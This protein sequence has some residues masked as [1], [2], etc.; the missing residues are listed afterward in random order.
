MQNARKA[1]RRAW[2]ASSRRVPGRRR[3]EAGLV[4]MALSWPC[5]AVAHHPVSSNSGVGLTG[6]QVSLGAPFTSHVATRWEMER[7]SAD[8]VL[9]ASTSHSLALRGS[10]AWSAAWTVWVEPTLL[11]LDEPDEEADHGF[12]DTRVAVLHKPDPHGASGWTLGAQLS[13]PT[14]AV[15]FVVDPGRI[16]QLAA[17][18]S[19]AWSVDAWRLEALGALIG[20]ESRAGHAVDAAL[21]AAVMH[22][23]PGGMQASLTWLAHVRAFAWCAQVGGGRAFCD[24]GRV[25]ELDRPTLALRSLLL[26]ALSAS[27]PGGLGLT[28]AAQLPITPRRDLDWGLRFS[29][30]FVLDSPR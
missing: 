28:A 25:T 23:L 7:A 10:Y 4:T 15:R 13:M 14:R 9:N 12:G 29:V 6:R 20:D 2:S 21:G 1:V 3:L 22:P 19:H 18:A 5:V 24:E 8:S 16:W 17:S 11:F 27:L 30:H 26:P